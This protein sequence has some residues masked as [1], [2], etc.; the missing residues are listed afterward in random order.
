MIDDH[1][2]CQWVN[3]SSGT[4]HP[5]CAGQIPE[6]HKMAVVEVDGT[7]YFNCKYVCDIF[8]NDLLC[9]STNLFVKYYS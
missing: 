8:R 7:F 4:A 2:R 9:I 1:D 5:G 3:V 6:S